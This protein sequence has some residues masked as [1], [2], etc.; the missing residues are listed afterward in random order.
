MS[1]GWMIRGREFGSCNCDWGC[2][3][4]FNAPTT[5]G[6]CE[7]AVDGIIDEGHFGGTR[8]DGLAFAM[9]LQWRGEI[10]DGN[11]RQQ[12]IVDARADGAQREALRKILRGEA[13]DTL[14]M[15]QSGVIR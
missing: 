13:T 10:A 9:T 14:H 3:C 11:G 1:E 5:H 2:P 12:T 15:N 7:A 6:F 4:Q 8:L